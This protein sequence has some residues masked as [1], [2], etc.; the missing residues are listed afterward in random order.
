MSAA[1]SHTIDFDLAFER[2]IETPRER[3]WRC[4]IEPELIKRWFTPAPWQTVD[5][6]IISGPAVFF[7]P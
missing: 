3:V 5:G 6:E 7:A 2:L 1:H 4:W